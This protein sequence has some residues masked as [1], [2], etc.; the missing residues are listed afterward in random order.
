M[1]RQVSMEEISD[2]RWYESNDMVKA[3]CNG[4]AGCS[5]CCQ[6]M[7]ESIV[8]DPLDVK[9]LMDGLGESFESLLEGKLALGV[10]D[11]ILLPHL[12]MTEPGNACP[13]LNG[14]GRCSVHAARPGLCRIFPLGRY[15]ENH[16]FRYFLQIHEC[17]QEPKTKVKVSKW[18][19]KPDPDWYEQYIT[20]WHYFLK[21]LQDYALEA[22]E[23]LVR[24]LNVYLLRQFFFAPYETEDFYGAFYRRLTEAKNTLQM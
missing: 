12:K 22:D 20:D 1:R 4:C 10:V 3:D 24:T 23:N 7:G 13:F 18:I 8:L 15:Y 19:E 16:T 21:E 14:E 5:A 9:R 2:G 6:D 17:R 11:G